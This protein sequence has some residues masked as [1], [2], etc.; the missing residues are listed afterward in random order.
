M[1]CPHRNQTL[2][3]PAH[4]GVKLC[5]V[6]PTKESDFVVSCPWRNQTLRCPT[7]FGVR[8]HGEHEMKIFWS[9]SNISKMKTYLFLRFTRALGRPDKFFKKIEKFSW[10][11]S[12]K[13]RYQELNNKVVVF[14]TKEVR[15]SSLCC[16][17]GIIWIQNVVFGQKNFLRGSISQ[18]VTLLT[19]SVS[20]SEK[21]YSWGNRMP[22]YLKLCNY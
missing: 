20:L 21:I 19:K 2:Q 12:L 4:G 15:I 7:H 13:I 16:S 18:S 1:P 5:G 8:V 3:C 9:N 14:L 11:T 17:M 10:H 6:L 22:S